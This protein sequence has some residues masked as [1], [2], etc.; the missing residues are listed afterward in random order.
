VSSRLLTSRRRG[1]GQ[2]NQ[3]DNKRRSDNLRGTSLVGAALNTSG[4]VSF[5]SPVLETP[6]EQ[7]R[8]W[9][10]NVSAEPYALG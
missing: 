9:A 4:W 5:G 2:S 10:N 8:V 6:D 1:A 7:Y 3:S